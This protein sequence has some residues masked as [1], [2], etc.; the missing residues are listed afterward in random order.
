MLINVSALVLL[1]YPRPL[2]TGNPD[3]VA[4]FVLSIVGVLFILISGWLGGQMVYVHGLAVDEDAGLLTAG[5]GNENSTSV[6][7][8]A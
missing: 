3:A 7:V 1:P 4:P 6:R 5:R 2:R 8:E